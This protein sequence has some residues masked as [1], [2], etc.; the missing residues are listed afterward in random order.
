MAQNWTTKEEARLQTLIDEGKDNEAIADMMGRTVDSI[1]QKRYKLKYKKPAATKQAQ[2]PI[3]GI[4]QEAKE[5]AFEVIND[6]AIHLI[7]IHRDSEGE[8][9]LYVDGQKR[10]QVLQAAL[11][12]LG[13]L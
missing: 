9:T 12:E 2:S 3:E 8:T 10:G 11:R 6:D 4:K 7:V 13:C 1:K 5:R